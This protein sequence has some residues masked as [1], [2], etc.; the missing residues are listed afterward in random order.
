MP[1]RGFPAFLVTGLAL[2]ALAYAS[3]FLPG[4]APGWA[5]WSFIVGT[6]TTFTAF[7]VT[8]ARKGGRLGWLVWP[9][10]FVFLALVGSLGA[11]LLLPPVDPAD[12]RLLLGLPLP[13]AV[14]ILGG[15]I[16]PLLVLPL[17]YA[18]DFGRDGLSPREVARIRDAAARAR[19]AGADP[20]PG[21][22]ARGER[23]TSTPA[24][25]SGEPGTGAEG[26]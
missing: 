4:G 10:G 18:M 16:L 15:G 25:P 24:G 23:A 8:G 22:G 9:F 26:P 5:P 17:A 14:V 3:A 2:V 19:A 20:P 7:L 1:A 21:D 11:G 12:P 13:A 6:A